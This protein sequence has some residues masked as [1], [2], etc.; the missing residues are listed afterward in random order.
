VGQQEGQIRNL[1][2]IAGKRKGEEEAGEEIGK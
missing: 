2:E 1:Y